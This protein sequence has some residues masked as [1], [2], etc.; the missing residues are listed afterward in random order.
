MILSEQHIMIRDMARQFAAEHLAPYAADWDRTATVPQGAL[1]EMGNLGLLGMLVPE[2]WG[3]AGLD[4]LAYVLA[5]EQIAG[6]DGGVSTIMSVNNSPVCSILTDYGTAEQK[7]RFLKPL[8]RGEM[9]GAFALTE[10]QAGSDASNLIMRARRDG[11]VYVLNGSKQ[12]IT[13]GHLAGVTIT[14]AVTGP[15]AGK[16]GISA[17]LVPTDTPG[18]QVATI[19]KKLGQHTSDT[20][21]LVFEDVVIPLDLRIGDEGDGYKIALANLEAGRIGVAAQAVGMAHAAY[22][23]ALAYAKERTSFGKPIIDHQA[24]GFRLADMITQIEAARQLVYHAATL[25]DAQ[26]PCLQAASMA[27]LFASEMAERVC[28][29][30]IQ[31][32]GGYG[33]LNEFPVERIYRDARVCQIYEGTSDIQR[34]VISRSLGAQ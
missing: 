15:E 14:F 8:A 28:S 19:E 29:D 5:L 9:I 13:S 27:K 6:G 3:G 16:R 34:L 24:V 2:E 30:A 7:A 33:Y 26:Q 17:F 12:F 1:K 32:H 25:R 20:C 31:I 23:H 10:P 18:Y 21:Q 22:A 4:Y 11:D